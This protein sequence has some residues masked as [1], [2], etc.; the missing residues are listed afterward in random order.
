MR[1]LTR[2]QPLWVL[3]AMLTV[4]LAACGG[5]DADTNAGAAASEAPADE[6]GGGEAATSDE[7]DTGIGAAQDLADEILDSAG[8]TATVTIGDE[9]LEFGLY[10]QIPMATCN[11]DFFGGFI[12]VLTTEGEL[13]DPLNLMSITLPGGDFQDPPTMTVNIGIGTEAEWI[14]EETV[15]EQTPELPAGIGVT[16]FSIDG[17]TATGTAVF[18]EQESFYQFTAGLVDELQMADGTFRVTCAE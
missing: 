6:D 3:L 17:T 2:N 9:T 8:G 15:Y 7:S 11:A 13:S 1:R 5:S 4:L 14:A 10:P 12:A 18:Y 16:G